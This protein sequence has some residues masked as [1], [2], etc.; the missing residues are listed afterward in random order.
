MEQENF[1]S[2][3]AHIHENKI[4]SGAHFDLTFKGVIH[5]MEQLVQLDRH[6]N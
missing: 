4:L 2:N 5:K 1:I 6:K 3:Q